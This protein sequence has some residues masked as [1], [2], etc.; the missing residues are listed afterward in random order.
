M[1]V[2]VHVACTQVRKHEE[3][4]CKC[5]S[6][7]GCPCYGVTVRARGTQGVGDGSVSWSFI[8]VFKKNVR[9]PPV[10]HRYWLGPRSQ[11]SA[12][13]V[14]L[15]FVCFLLFFGVCDL[16]P[17]IALDVVQTRLTSPR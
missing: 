9:L 13:L 7:V 6:G 17:V 5:G 3:G 14:L 10:L 16:D 15:F 2:C 12:C 8:Q 4:L 1:R 11:D